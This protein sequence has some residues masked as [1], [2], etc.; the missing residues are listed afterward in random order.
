VSRVVVTWLELT[1]VGLT[2]GILGTA[3]GGP[4]GLIV[5]FVTTLV[6]VGIVFYNVNELIKRW[7]SYRSMH[8]RNR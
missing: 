8:D 1:F 7:M 3:V 2:G 5:Y 4:L 6:S